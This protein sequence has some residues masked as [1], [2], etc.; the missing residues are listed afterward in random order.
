MVR[1]IVSFTDFC[2]LARRSSHTRDDLEQMESALQSFLEHRTVFTQYEIRDKNFCLPRQHSM[3]HYVSGI[4]LFG[5]PNGLCSSI[6]E[7]KHIAAVKKLWRASNRNNALLQI[8]EA[9]VQLSKLSAL[10][11]EFGHRG[12]LC[13]DVLTAAR[14]Q[15]GLADASELVPREVACVVAGKPNNVVDDEDA[16]QAQPGPYADYHTTLSSWPGMLLCFCFDIY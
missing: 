1:C 14:V 7:S 6:T 3:V 10:R 12:M 5:S 11:I 16:V 15:M 13:G 8:L 2:Y 4:Q 9:N